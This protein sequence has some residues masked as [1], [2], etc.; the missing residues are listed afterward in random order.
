MCLARPIRDG[1][2]RVTALVRM[3]GSIL[4]VIVIG[5]VLGGLY[6]L[7]AIGFTLIMGIRGVINIAHGS[8]IMIGAFTFLALG[9]HLPPSVS[10]IFATFLAG[11]LSLVLYIG[12][13]R[14]IEEDL[15]LTFMITLVI[16]ITLQ[17]V[18]IDLFSLA[19]RSLP[20]LVSGGFQFSG[21]RIRYNLLL[22]FVISWIVIILLVYFVNYTMTGRS[23]LA[24]SMNEEGAKLMGVDLFRINAI[25]WLIA[26]FMAG[27]SGVFFG[28]F[29]ETSPEMW[30]EPLAL[31]FIIVTVGGIGSVKGSIAAAYLIG[32]V[33][34]ITSVMIGSQY[35]GLFS[36]LLLVLVI[37]YRP[38][39][40]FGRELVE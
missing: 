2:A 30:L 27:L 28:S 25:T 17:Y 8:L 20:A 10:L 34:S 35:R 32:Y 26:G 19:P 13:V 39:G 37:V 29:Q 23:I 18:F 36:L 5:S 14:Y 11:I 40:M 33:E 38:E 7:I 6:S 24:V 3:I 16:A 15:V 4:D 12:V 21:T 31:S 22:A 1:G 9:A